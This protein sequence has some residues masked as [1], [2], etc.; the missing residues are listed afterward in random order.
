MGGVSTPGGFAAPAVNEA[1]CWGWLM[2][3]GEI[4]DPARPWTRTAFSERHGLGRAFLA[5]RMRELGLATSIDAAG[6]LIGR[7]EGTEPSVGTIMIGSHSDTVVGGGRFDGI[8]GV[9]AGLEIAAA[10]RDGGVRLR[11]ALEIV[12][13]LAEEPNEFGL[14][15]VGSRGMA[16]A[17]DEGLLGRRNRA[18]GTLREGMG[19]GGWGG[20]WGGFGHR[21]V[22]VCPTAALAWV[23][24]LGRAAERVAG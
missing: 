2:Q 17:L 1:R 22:G 7:W 9:I 21:L 19:G 24:G 4:T 12:D 18:G 23:A 14:S 20:G 5:A 6:N 3:L 8:A 15:C 13:F 10:L 16:G 11:H